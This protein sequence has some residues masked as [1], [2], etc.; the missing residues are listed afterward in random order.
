MPLILDN[1]I[2]VENIKTAKI[3]KIIIDIYHT[4]MEIIYDL[5]HLEGSNFI[6]VERKKTYIQNNDFYKI[7]LEHTTDNSRYDDIKIVENK[8]TPLFWS[9]YKVDIMK[10][11]RTDFIQFHPM[12]SNIS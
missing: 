1:E 9:Y 11:M 7:A 12:I 2:H 8:N 10:S 6:A 5:G 4:R 3:A